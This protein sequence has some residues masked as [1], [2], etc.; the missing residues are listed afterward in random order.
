M[1]QKRLRLQQET[2]TVVQSIRGNLS[3]AAKRIQG[4]DASIRKLQQ[5]A[6]KKMV[7][8]IDLTSNE[9]KQA[10][11]LASFR[12][13]LNE[14]SVYVAKTGNILDKEKVER[15]YENL[16]GPIN[17]MQLYIKL[18]TWEDKQTG[19]DISNKLNE[20]S[21]KLGV[22]K[23]NQLKFLASRDAPAAAKV[24]QTAKNADVD[25]SY[26]QTMARVEISKAKTSLEQSTEEMTSSIVAFSDTNTILILSSKI[27]FSSAVTV[28]YTHLTLPTN[29][30]V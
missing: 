12:D 22:L 28:S 2:Q 24:A 29:R 20:L 8:N 14:I 25:I 30:E 7:T 27:N 9:N 6:A 15:T 17:A 11:S 21:A 10:T 3:E 4:L 16:D 18:I 5:G 13:I 19:E 26:L 23:D 1:T